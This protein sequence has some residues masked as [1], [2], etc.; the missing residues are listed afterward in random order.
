M[1]ENPK[2]HA[3]DLDL[4]N[5]SLDLS[6]LSAEEL[7]ELVRMLQRRVNKCQLLAEKVIEL[8]LNEH[9]DFTV[10]IKDLDFLDLDGAGEGA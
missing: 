1:S 7:I 3:L 9:G 8:F 5:L 4:S 10:L 6:H 2:N